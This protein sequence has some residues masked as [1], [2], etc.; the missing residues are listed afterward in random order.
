MRLPS[1]IP[2]PGFTHPA[3]SPEQAAWIRAWLDEPRRYPTLFL[4]IPQR[5][6]VSFTT[7]AGPIRPADPWPLREIVCR[8]VAAPAP[9]VG[10]PHEYRWRVGIDGLGR[11]VASQIVTRERS[12]VYRPWPA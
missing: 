7:D 6:S 5:P 2:D 12:L 9:Y 3:Y 8:T 1:I 4:P 11:C 10:D